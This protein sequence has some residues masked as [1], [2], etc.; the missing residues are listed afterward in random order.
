[1]EQ[2]SAEDVK[3]G[4]TVEVTAEGSIE[5]LD[6]GGTVR[7]EKG[8]V[9]DA[10][11]GGTME[12]GGPLKF[13]DLDIGGRL[14][15]GSGAGERV[16][17]GG[18]LEVVGDLVLSDDLD[19]GG[20]ARV[21]GSLDAGSVG[22]GGDLKSEVVRA[23]DDVKVGRS[24]TTD[25]GVKGDF[26]SVGRLGRVTGPIVAKEVRIEDDSEVEDVY[27]EELRIG[28]SSRAKNVYASK[29]DVGDKCRVSGKL[30]YTEELRIGR[31]VQFSSQPEKVSSLPSPPI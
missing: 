17:V 29:V 9:Q 30:Q 6:V 3:V 31:D 2:I 15:L 23:H 11:V 13:V 21:G 7:L 28:E 20:E 10:R 8:R 1:V 22:V 19:V 4:A 5:D 27:A 25:K 12:G 14:K 26:V 18:V 24:I 16:K